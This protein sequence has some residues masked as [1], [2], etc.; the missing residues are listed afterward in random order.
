[1]SEKKLVAKYVAQAAQRA[2]P[3]LIED[4]AIPSVTSGKTA[5]AAIT[6]IVTQ[7]AAGASKRIWSM[8]L[9]IAAS[10]MM[11]ALLDPSTQVAVRAWLTANT[12][13]Y[14]PVL[15]PLGGALLAY[16]SRYFDPRPVR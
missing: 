14:A 2:V 6:Q 3:L 15:I 8:V 7:P 4:D 12:G 1:M 16:L 13:I 5:E 9:G 10:A 11:A